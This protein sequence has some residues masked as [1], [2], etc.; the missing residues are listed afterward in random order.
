MWC[1][2]GQIGNKIF[3]C[4]LCWLLA[5][6]L[7]KQYLINPNHN[8]TKFVYFLTHGIKFKFLFN[9]NTK[10]KYKILSNNYFIF[11]YICTYERQ[12]YKANVNNKFF[13]T[14]LKGKTCKEHFREK[15]TIK[16][17]YAKALSIMQLNFMNWFSFIQGK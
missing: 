6:G 1:S 16:D 4:R 5:S 7:G 2:S 10:N 13:T 9:K 15:Y 3:H 17:A 11:L 12:N 14:T 8:D